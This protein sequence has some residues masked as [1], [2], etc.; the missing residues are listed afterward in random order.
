MN[1]W[2][3]E[4]MNWFCCW[5]IFRYF[6][7]VDEDNGQEFSQQKRTTKTRRCPPTFDQ[8]QGSLGMQ[9]VSSFSFFFFF[10]FTLFE[11]QFFSSSDRVFFLGAAIS[12][13]TTS[14]YI[15]PGLRT[16][17][18]TAQSMGDPF[19][20]CFRDL[21]LSSLFLSLCLD[22]KSV[23]WLIDWM[24]ID[25]NT[26][27]RRVSHRCCVKWRWW[28]AVL[29]PLNPCPNRASAAPSSLASALL[30]TDPIDL[31]SFSFSFTL[32]LSSCHF[33]SPLCPLFS[34]LSR[35]PRNDP[36]KE[37]KN[38]ILLASHR[39]A[40]QNR[41]WRIRE[42]RNGRK[43]GFTWGGCND[44]QRMFRS[45]QSETFPWQHGSTVAKCFPSTWSRRS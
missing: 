24:L 40:F 43:R 20:V 1:W 41:W 15:V 6:A 35:C 3:D 21:F 28:S 13:D 45:R 38:S 44:S 2:N 10:S 23:D 36:K 29:I 12:Q 9:F 37:E 34:F 39:L 25:G 19:K 5:S 42:E 4:M 33:I 31:L 30:L 8:L 16:L 17:L 18:Q 11:M 14:M 32:L 26:N 27:K 22:S 7:Q